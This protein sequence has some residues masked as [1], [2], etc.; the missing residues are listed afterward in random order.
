M[1][2][3]KFSQKSIASKKF[4][5]KEVTELMEIDVNKVFSSDQI[6]CSNGKDWR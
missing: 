6:P 4:N 3:L 1:T 2:T 5:E